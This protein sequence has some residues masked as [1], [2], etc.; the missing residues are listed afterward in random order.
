MEFVPAL[1]ATPPTI[2][3]LYLTEFTGWLI[4]S[5]PPT[6]IPD[7]SGAESCPSY[8]AAALSRVTGPLFQTPTQARRGWYCVSHKRASVFAAA[9]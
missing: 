5:A 9:S 2:R 4:Y 1:S 7:H 8:P 6:I 3:S